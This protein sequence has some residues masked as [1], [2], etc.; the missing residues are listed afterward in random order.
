MDGDQIGYLKFAAVRTCPKPIR[1]R[2]GEDLAAGV[3]RSRRCHFIAKVE[4]VGVGAID[5]GAP[6]MR[7]GY[8]TNLTCA[9]GA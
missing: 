3:T 2:A 6:V 1:C 9:P 5:K 8:E 7:W 4:G